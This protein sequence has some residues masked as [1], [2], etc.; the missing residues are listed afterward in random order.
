MNRR[1]LLAGLA[2]APAAA[3]V[4]VPARAAETACRLFRVTRGG[5]DIGRHRLEAR[6]DEDGFSITIEADIAVTFLGFT[7][8]RYTLSNRELWREQLLIR[9]DSEVDDDG[10]SHYAKMRGGPAG[11]EVDGSEYSGRVDRRA[12]TTSYFVPAFLERSPW[13]STQ[14]GRPLSIETRALEERGRWRVAGELETPLTLEYDRSG[15]WI[16]S[17]FTARGE[18]GRYELVEETGSIGT[19]WQRA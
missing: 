6:L 3:A 17:R 4:P 15:E 18:E 1:T 5:S 16:G 10:E 12:V 13:I 2:F 7:A 19:L 14:S 11:I 8:Y 9:A